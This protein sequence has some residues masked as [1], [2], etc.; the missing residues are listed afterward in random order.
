MNDYGNFIRC[1]KTSDEAKE[2]ALC[3]A[4][5]NGGDRFTLITELDPIEDQKRRVE[6]YEAY[7]A[8]QK[9]YKKIMDV[10]VN[11]DIYPDN[12]AGGGAYLIGAILEGVPEITEKQLMYIRHDLPWVLEKRTQATIEKELQ[13]SLDIIKK[14]E[15]D[16]A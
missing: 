6:R 16:N 9:Y 5:A 11:A 1:F 4:N 15:E 3:F 7:M 12:T 10:I 13:R 2:Y 8:Y 14:M